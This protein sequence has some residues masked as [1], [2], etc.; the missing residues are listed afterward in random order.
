[1]AYFIYK[2]RVGHSTGERT[3]AREGE[4]FTHEPIV[5]YSEHR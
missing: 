2:V 5:F 3:A 4:R 1:M